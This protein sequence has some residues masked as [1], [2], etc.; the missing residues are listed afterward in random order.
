MFANAHDPKLAQGTSQIEQL[1][2]QKTVNYNNAPQPGGIGLPPSQVLVNFIDNHDVDRFLFDAKGDLPALRNA[3]TLNMTAEG[4]PCLYYGTEQDFDGGNDPAN[5]EVLW[6]T[7]FPTTGA[8]FTH[9]V[10]LAAIR[11]AYVAIRRGGTQVRWSTDDVSGTRTT[12][13][14]SPSS[15][16]AATRAPQYCPGG[17]QHERLP[18]ERHL[19]CQRSH[20]GRRCGARHRAGRRP[21][22]GPHDLHR[23]DLD[24]TMNLTVPPQS[25]MIL[26]PQAQVVSGT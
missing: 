18:V 23:W 6:T 19:E 2:D 10:Q 14:S 16:R 7:G 9:I 24:G 3:L 1:W 17:P 8:T 26:I 13:A 4:I 20:H 25:A 15:G 11:K 5:R 12:R 22:P 21:Q